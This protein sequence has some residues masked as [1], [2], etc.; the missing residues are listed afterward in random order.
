MPCSTYSGLPVQIRAGTGGDEAAL[1]A[2]D[3]VRMFSRYAM[4][5]NW[6]VQLVNSST[7]ENGGVKE[8]VLQVCV[9]ACMLCGVAILSAWSAVW[10]LLGQP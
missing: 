5:Q 2:A 6:K 9:H 3:L 10:M 7:L 1:W 8:T 4:E